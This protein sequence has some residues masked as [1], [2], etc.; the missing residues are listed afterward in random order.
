MIDESPVMAIP[1]KRAA[2]AA[3]PMET[4]Q[5]AYIGRV[6]CVVVPLVL[7]FAPFQIPDTTKHA[8]AIVSFM[9][10]AWI[11]EAIDHALA[12]LIGC[13]LFWALKVVSFNVAF[14]GFANDTAWFLVGAML[15]GTMAAKS[16]LARRLA[17]LVVLR[18]GQTYSRLL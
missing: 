6:L 2:A 4:S 1:E 11:T 7:W 3:R 12:G 8:L 5:R 10:L 9:I 18:V 15:F 17:Y 16:G 13:Y 14:S